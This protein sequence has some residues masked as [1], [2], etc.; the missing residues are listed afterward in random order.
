MRFVQLGS[1]RNTIRHS[2]QLG[3]IILKDGMA[4]ISWFNTTL[5]INN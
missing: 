4:A 5:K 3:E 2:R 1:L